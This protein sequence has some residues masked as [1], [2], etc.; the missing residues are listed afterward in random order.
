MNNYQSRLS[1]FINHKGIGVT[2]FERKIKSS[3]GAIAKA[4]HG[5]DI[6]VS[7]LISILNTFPEINTTWLLTGQ[8]EMIKNHEAVNEEIHT[9]RE[10]ILDLE[11]DVAEREKL[12]IQYKQWSDW[13]NKHPW[14]ALWNRITAPLFLMTTPELSVDPDK[15]PTVFR[16][17]QQAEQD[18][19]D[20]LSQFSSQS[21][22]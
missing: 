14:R 11:H 18:W 19:K 2:A 22:C 13:A 6:S 9:L 21:S 1:I 16:T 3:K 15:Q 4:L 12:L 5:K 7:R 10:R 8:G 17:R 20:I